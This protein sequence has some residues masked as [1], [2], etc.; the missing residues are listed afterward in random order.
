M[1]HMLHRNACKRKL[2]YKGGKKMIQMIAS[3][4][5]GSENLL[6]EKDKSTG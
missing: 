4:F 2:P 5:K 3:C 6:W 1:V